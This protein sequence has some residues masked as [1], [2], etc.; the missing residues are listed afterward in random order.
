MPAP[1][2]VPDKPGEGRRLGPA[3]GR[4]ARWVP[5][6]V[7]L[8][9]AILRVVY[10]WGCDV[11]NVYDDHFH[12]IVTMLHEKR[13]PRPDEG[14]Q[15][16][17]PPLY[18]VLGA[19][20]YCLAAGRT[21]VLPYWM[22]Q[23]RSDPGY[24][25]HVAGRKAV[26]FLSTI[27]GI[28]TLALVWLT[29]RHLF[30]GA[31]FAQSV[32]MGLVAF[33]PRHIYMSAM[34]TNDA[35]TYLW[36]SLCL[37]AVLRGLGLPTAHS[38]S[39]NVGPRRERP[40]R[41]AYGLYPRSGG[42]DQAGAQIDERAGPER[43][44]LESKAGRAGRRWLGYLGSG[45][46]FWVPAGLAAAL[47]MWTKQYGL[48]ALG[49]LL[50]AVLAGVLTRSA[51]VRGPR[52]AGALLATVLAIALG[53][54]PYVRTYRLT[55]NPVAS[56][57]T[58]RPHKMDSQLPGKL[59]EVSFASLRLG[60]L[61]ARPW[62][63]LSTVDSF[64]SE[65]YGELWFDYGT[66]MTAYQYRPWIEYVWPIWKDESITARERERRGLIWD[67]GVMPASQL[68]HGRLL[69]ALGALPTVLCLVGL[70]AIWRQIPAAVAWVTVV[71]FLLGLATPI[72][73]TV[74]QPFR[75][76]M[77][78]TFALSALVALSVLLV[79]GC[80]WI[81]QRRY[82][83]WLRWVVVVNL[84]VLAVVAGWHFLELALIFPASPLYFPRRDPL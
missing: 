61:L 44:S 50:A 27:S 13:W 43:G 4:M 84:V 2:L 81:G 8:A 5:L 12:V 46:R 63:H 17:Q 59:S 29:L 57:Y 48:G 28:A 51:S 20:A 16:Y 60:R 19:L 14:W 79:V 36:A 71:S 67:A 11:R 23:A 53:I 65:V 80:C 40:G 30:A 55:G 24:A 15:T 7:L 33:L 38:R 37:Y 52:I 76:S 39:R 75:S 83:S 32:G 66:A 58:L 82:L 72:F 34:A 35:M 22:P 47:A 64:W 10:T 9:G 25:R 56:N 77:K 69:I 21:D 54:W 73:Q 42:R 62:V 3:G 6:V 31:W 49:T 74:R 41:R 70:I 68:W 45:L 1:A 78:A 18:H 26:Q